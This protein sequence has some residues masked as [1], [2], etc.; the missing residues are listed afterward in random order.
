MWMG[1]MN[2]NQEIELLEA[3]RK[4]PAD[5]RAMILR[6]TQTSAHIF[7]QELDQAIAEVEALAST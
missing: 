3:F 7:H 1:S 5:A 4:N 2:K 6:L